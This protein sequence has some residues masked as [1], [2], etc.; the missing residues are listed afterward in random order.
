MSRAGMRPVGAAAAAVA[1]ALFGLLAWAV[2]AGATD[3]WDTQ[4]N[5]AIHDNASDALTSLALALSFIGSALVWAPITAGAVIT[6]V[7][8]GWRKAAVDLAIVMTG[9]VL[10]ENGLKLAFA[11]TRPDVY[12][13]A[14]PSTF[15]FPSGHAIFAA[16]LYGALACLIADRISSRAGGVALWAAAVVIAGLIGASRLYLGMHYASDVAAGYL[17]AIFWIGAVTALRAG[18][19]P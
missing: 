3:V 8:L 19:K 18:D 13:G 15:G 14:L 11:R 12:F 6:F 10:L 16:C 5:A 7:W 17:V 4:I 2:V 1:F 9:A